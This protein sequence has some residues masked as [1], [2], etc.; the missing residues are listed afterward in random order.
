MRTCE[1]CFNCVVRLH[2]ESNP[3][4][5]HPKKFKKNWA[6]AHIHYGQVRCQQGHWQT[7]ENKEY[8]YE[9]LEKLWGYKGKEHIYKV[10]WP[11]KRWRQGAGC[12]DYRG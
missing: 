4:S 1:T 6:N 9:S 12:I 11:P 5:P 7:G 3:H 8:T 10:K 2:I